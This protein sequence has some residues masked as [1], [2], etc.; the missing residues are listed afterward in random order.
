MSEVTDTGVVRTAVQVDGEA[1][2]DL[3]VEQDGPVVLLLHGTYW[4]RVWFP[5]LG[6]L[7]R[8]GYGPLRSISPDWGIRQASSPWKRPRSRPSRIGWCDS[9]RR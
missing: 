7:A 1:A 3:T 2:S 6:R 9:P 4:S 5:V 8:R